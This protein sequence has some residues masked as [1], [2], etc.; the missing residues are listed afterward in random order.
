V[1]R[2]PRSSFFVVLQRLNIFSAAVLIGVGLLL[3]SS[4]ARAQL[5]SASVNGTVQDSSGAVIE[6]AQLT[7]RNASTGTQRETTTNSTGNYAFLDS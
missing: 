1:T 6:G 3:S 7:L 2:E 4:S 5:T